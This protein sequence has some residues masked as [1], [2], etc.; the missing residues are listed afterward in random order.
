MT[1]SIAHVLFESSGNHAVVEDSANDDWVALIGALDGERFD[2][3]VQRYYLAQSHFRKQRA[4]PALPG[5]IEV[6]ADGKQQAMAGM[7]ELMDERKAA[8]KR[9]V[10][11]PAAA[12]VFVDPI[13][14]DDALPGALKD[15][16]IMPPPLSNLLGG[17]GRPPCDALCLLR[18]FLAAP[19]LGVGDDPTSVFRLLHS[20]PAFAHICDFLGQ[21][22]MRVPGELTSRRLPCLSVC[23]D[24]SEIMTRYGLWHLARIEQVVANVSSGAVEVESTVTFDT[25]HLVA[26][27]HC[28]NAVPA[29]AAEAADGKKPKHRKVPRMQKR[30]DCGKENWA[31]CPHSWVPTDQGAAVVVKGPTRIYWAHK[32]SV[33]AFAFSEVPFDIRVCLYA[34]ESDSSTLVPHLELL[35]YD[36]PWVLDQLC[37][38]LADDGY[39]GNTEQVAAFGQDAR[40]ILPVHPRKASAIL[41]S[42]FEGIH[43]F[44]PIG[45]PVCDEGHR[46]EMRGRDIMGERYIWVAPDDPIGQPVCASC[47]SA[48]TCLHKGQRRNIRVNRQDQP[49]ISWEH[50]QHF[51][52]DRDRYRRRTGVERAIKRLKVDLKGE[53]LTHRNAIRVQAHLDRKLL[54]LHLLLAVAHPT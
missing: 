41:A 54:T 9:A 28:A 29:D 40:L 33:A 27:S 17:A 42:S 6:E 18:A 4:R 34:A 2:V 16:A 52:R 53:H 11:Q 38:V 51:A 50:P 37:F 26:N 31:T 19:L 43:H 36:M 30:C 13:P 3:L 47:P 22:S 45:I 49:Q 5:Q 24:F 7:L 32:A 12:D 23:E 35:Q 46:F 10:G 15:F 39:Q 48:Q 1:P 21:G 25:T 14:A 44:T 8:R 20:N